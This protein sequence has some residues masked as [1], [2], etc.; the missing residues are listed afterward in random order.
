MN[1]RLERS[2]QVKRKSSGLVC[3]PTFW[4]LRVVFCLRTFHD[5]PKGDGQ[6]D[7]SGKPN[8]RRKLKCDRMVRRWAPRLRKENSMMQTTLILS[9]GLFLAPMAAIAQSTLFDFNR[10]NRTPRSRSTKLAETFG[11]TLPPLARDIRSNT[12]PMRSR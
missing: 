12:R 2:F 1:L 3:L 10:G 11:R 4:W 9:V 8:I 7:G 6:K 5:G